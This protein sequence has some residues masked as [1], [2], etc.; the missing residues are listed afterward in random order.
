MNKNLEIITSR[1]LDSKGVLHSLIGRRYL[2][3]AITTCIE[4]NKVMINMGDIYNEIAA[5]HE[6]ASP[7][8]VERCMRHAIRQSNSPIKNKEFICR[9]VYDIRHNM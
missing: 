2:L 4:D 5:A 8:N 7:S 3:E 1:Y 6:N 9:A